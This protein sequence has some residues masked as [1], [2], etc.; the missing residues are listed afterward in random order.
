[1]TVT[2]QF[3]S[4]DPHVYI[5]K[6]C[7]SKG[8]PQNDNMSKVLYLLESQVECVDTFYQSFYNKYHFFVGQDGFQVNYDSCNEKYYLSTC[9]IS[10]DDLKHELDNIDPDYFR[11]ADTDL[12]SIKDNDL[13][14]FQALSYNGYGWGDMGQ[15]FDNIGD[16]FAMIFGYGQLSE[17]S[18]AIERNFY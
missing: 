2:T 16:I 7:V 12:E 5:Q 1:M 14:I 11:Y 9:W 6:A 13:E 4:M 3:E 15:S 18:N 17:L 8:K 10:K